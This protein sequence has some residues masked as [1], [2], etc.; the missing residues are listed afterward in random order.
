MRPLGPRPLGLDWCLPSAA[1]RRF[2]MVEELFTT[3]CRTHAA[4]MRLDRKDVP[5]RKQ[6][7]SITQGSRP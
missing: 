4:S 5:Q 7:A 1:G 2:N 3:L 6:A